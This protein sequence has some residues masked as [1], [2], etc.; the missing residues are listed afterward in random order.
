MSNSDYIAWFRH[1][2]PYINAYRGKTFVLTLPGDAMEN[3]NFQHIVHDIA[4][5]TSLGV[6]LVL[7]HGARPQIEARLKEAR[8]ESEFSDGKRITDISSLPYV[9]QAIGATRLKLEAALS[10]GLPNSPMHGADIRLTSGNF[11]TGMP[12]GVINGVDYQHSGKVRKIDIS[13]IHHAL[14]HKAVVIISP[15]GYSAT[16]EVFNIPVH[17][18]ATQVAI[19]LTADKL[20]TLIRPQGINDD[21]GN[22][23][24]HLSLSACREYLSNAQL[25]EEQLAA[26]EASY[27]VCLQGVNRAQVISYAIDGALIE[28][29]FTRNGSGTLVHRDSY[30]IIR[31]AR[32]GDV[33]GILALIQPLEEQGILVRRSRELLETEIYRFAVMELDG[34][35]VACAGLYAFEDDNMAELAC[36]ATHEEY[37]NAGR[38]EQLL[39]YIESQAKLQGMESIFVL[40]TQTAHWFLERGFIEKPL[41]VLPQQKQTLYNLQRRSKVFI[42]AI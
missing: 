30:E 29:L 4:L 6:R 42:K 7:V 35:I 27:Q 36:V 2:S 40:T 31:Q 34:M 13:S 3:D 38:A 21:N 11:V 15:I 10:T 18:V 41:S 23:Q 28:E 22:L 16:G 12:K 24:R 33:G 1:S 9:L 14:D 5:L 19:A 25:P 20:I 39:E 17:E 8:V 32:I 37:R 26:L